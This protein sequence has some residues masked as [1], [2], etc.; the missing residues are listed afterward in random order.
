MLAWGIEQGDMLVVEKNDN[1]AVGDFVVLE[2]GN[3]FHI[4]EFISHNDEFI[5]MALDSQMHNIKTKDWTSLPIIGTVTN[6]IHQIQPRRN[7]LKFAA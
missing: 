6:T 2:T 5:F 4:Y 7:G 3:E 1:L